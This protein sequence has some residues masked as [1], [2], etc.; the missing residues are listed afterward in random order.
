MEEHSANHSHSNLAAMIKEYLPILLIYLAISLVVFWPIVTNIAH[1]TVNGAGDLY[2][3]LWNMWWVG[4][5][6]LTLHTSIYFT[7]LLY[8]PVGASLVTQTLSPISAFI[9]L[10]FQAVNLVFS[11]NIIFFISF[12]LCGLFMYLLADY[13]VKNKYAAF[14]A[15]L[16][17][18]F[19]PMHLAQAFAGHINWTNIEFLPLFILFFLLMIKDKKLIYSLGAAV[20]FVFLLFMGDPEQ[21]II[22]ALFIIMLLVIYA[23]SKTR[24]VE[25]F[26][27]KFALSFVAMIILTLI[28]G[29]PFLLPISSAFTNGT[30]GAASGQLN[31]V[32]HNMLWSDPISSFFLPS[33]YNNFFRWLS[34]SYNSIYSV[35]PI[36][37]ISYI[38]Y[39]AG[40]LAILGI[41]YEWRKNK[42]SN[43]LPWVAAL[44]LFG[45]LALGPYLQL[46]SL[47]LTATPSGIPG[48]YLIYRV[49]PFFNLIRE[50]ARFDMIFTLALAILAAYGFK[51]IVGMAKSKKPELIH[52]ERKYAAIIAILILIEYAGIPF[53]SQFI[54]S[55]F[56]TPTIP[57]AYS[58]IGSIPG[59][60]SVVMLP[61]IQGNSAITPELYLGLSMYYQ[62]A[63]HKAIISGYTSRV[64]ETELLP[65][66]SLPLAVGASYLQQGQGFVY[67]SP[68]VENYTNVTL[69]WLINYRAVFVSVIRQAYNI[70]EQTTLGN[71]LSGLFGLPVYQD[72]STIVFSTANATKKLGNALVSYTAGT[73]IPGYTLCSNQFLCN[74]TFGSLWWGPNVRAIDVYASNATTVKMSFIA[75]AYSS[76]TT[77]FQV[78]LNSVSSPTASFTLASSQLQAF[79]ATL[80]LTAGI[81]QLFFVGQNTTVA[82]SPGSAYLNFGIENLTFTR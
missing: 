64:N 59:N 29:S 42:T 12:M 78:Y 38:G 57:L 71:Y 51:E 4:Y 23:L 52:T 61:A 13:L 47:S 16:I 32:A 46:G 8:Y 30:L 69:F 75:A 74:A 2:Q 28:I 82:S 66:L 17:F 27:R 14:I 40:I 73:W 65:S 77:S 79:N 26:N 6:T 9:S 72:N 33:P 55:A 5:A 54:S 43:I 3:N 35:D 49:I 68:I 76:S 81:N 67:P 31:D 56:V 63:S 60:F 41:W 20:S 25:I 7:P 10:P 58:Q 1:T 45:W 11:Y 53:A 80:H 19:S 34:N 37:R 50:P 48:I 15:G 18:A 21:G 62:T 36:E 24:R 44:V 39:V 22:T 70:S